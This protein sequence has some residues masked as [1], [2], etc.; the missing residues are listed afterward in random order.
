MCPRSSIGPNDLCPCGSNK[1]HKRCCM[2]VGAS[3]LKKWTGPVLGVLIT[4][5]IAGL[6]LGLTNQA[7]SASSAGFG[8]GLAPPGKVWS[9]EHGHWHDAQ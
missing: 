9:V 7:K 3:G 6:V 5:G 8:P 4:V 1:K 2:S